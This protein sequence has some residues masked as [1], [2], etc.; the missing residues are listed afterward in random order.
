MKFFIILLL[1]FICDSIFSIDIIYMSNNDKI[2]GSIVEMSKESIII[3]TEYGKLK[4]N[5]TYVT[6]AELSANFDE[7]SNTNNILLKYLFDNNIKNTSTIPST[8]VV[9][10]TLT[11]STDIDNIEQSCLEN[12]ETGTYISINNNSQLMNYNDFCICFMICPTDPNRT[13]Y[14]FSQWN[15]TKETQA[16]GKLAISFKKDVLIIYLVDTEGIYHTYTI[17]NIIEYNTW[18]SII[19]NKNN[20]TLALFKNNGLIKSIDLG[21]HDLLQTE[22]TIILLSARYRDKDFSSYSYLGKIDQ[23]F[24]YNKALKENSISHFYTGKSF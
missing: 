1:L 12:R 3:E 14:I 23:L 20:S 16:D 10:G 7:N 4:I 9:S 2:S 17:P 24:F 22:A 18:Q 11:F 6:K 21:F 15:S 13:Q 5:R 19:I 8:Q